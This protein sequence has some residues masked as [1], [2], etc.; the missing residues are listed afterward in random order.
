M[1][2]N[3]LK[4]SKDFPFV[5][6]DYMEYKC[7][8]CDKKITSDI[9]GPESWVYVQLRPKSYDFC[10]LSCAF[11]GVGKLMYSQAKKHTMET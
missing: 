2:T 10:G 9:N 5:Q 8:Q 1:R 6:H 4:Q 3:I 11:K 7:D